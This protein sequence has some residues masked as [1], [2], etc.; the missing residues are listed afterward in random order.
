VK[1]FVDADGEPARLALAAGPWLVKPNLAE[2]EQLLA[3]SLT[4]PAEVLRGARELVRGGVEVAA[5]SMGQEGAFCVGREAAW[6]IRPPEVERRST[7]GSG[8]SLVAGI[9]VA[10][11][12]GDA[13]EEGL[14]LG[15]AAGAATAMTPGTALGTPEEIACLLPAVRID[16]L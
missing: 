11:A 16:R 4:N 10:V 15:T 7:I 9:A 5:I 14:R 1:A 3:R 12:N 6:R 13:L 2:A 8:D